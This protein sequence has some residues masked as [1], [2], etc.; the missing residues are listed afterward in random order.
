MTRALLSI[1]AL[2]LAACSTPPLERAA[3]PAGEVAPSAP[4]PACVYEVDGAPTA[5]LSAPNRHA[6]AAAG[7]KVL[8]AHE[9]R[10]GESMTIR[11]RLIDPT[12]PPGA[13]LLLSAADG[14]STRA[15]V[16]AHGSRFMVTW[17]Q[18]SQ[19]QKS[20]G[21]W[22][23][24]DGTLGPI[25][26]LPFDGHDG[27]DLVARGSGFAAAYIERGDRGYTL[28]RMLLDGDLTPIA[29]ALPVDDA[30]VFASIA[31]LVRANGEIWQLVEGAGRKGDTTQIHLVRLD[32]NGTVI[33]TVDEVSSS[34][35]NATMPGVVEVTGGVLVAWGEQEKEGRPGSV[36][37][38]K[39]DGS[40][41]P[42]G[43]ALM[44]RD[45][46]LSWG[47][48]ALVIDQGEPLLIIQGGLNMRLDTNGVPKAKATALPQ[49]GDRPIWLATEPT[50]SLA[51]VELP[52]D[53]VAL[54]F[55]P[56]RCVRSQ[57][58][59]EGR[60]LIRGEERGP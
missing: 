1:L 12:Q 3:E 44:V 16:I 14:F 59:R 23:S 41:K 37:T 58:E 38:R 47:G 15:Q 42:V 4:T 60:R 11:G 35:V 54:V 7:G 19:P 32:A 5:L 18:E 56:L 24:A 29:P 17:R 8:A 43:P 31:Q 30:R 33:G 26:D 48:L 22:V 40:G 27:M 28:Y 21:R 34:K 51:W 10:E 2:G 49:W 25:L 55:A 36:W 20:Q 50:P 6:A 13:E 45:G 46:S 39:L 52:A 9:V 57:K 53:G